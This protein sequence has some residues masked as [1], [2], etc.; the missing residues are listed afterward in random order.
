MRLPCMVLSS[1]NRSSAFMGTSASS[2]AMVSCAWRCV[3]FTIVGHMGVGE[4]VQREG[5]D[6]AVGDLLRWCCMHAR[7]SYVHACIH[8][9][10]TVCSLKCID[11]PSRPSVAAA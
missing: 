9:I 8:V 7:M 2:R 10:A 11:S 3:W 1:L 4:G 6:C 5:R